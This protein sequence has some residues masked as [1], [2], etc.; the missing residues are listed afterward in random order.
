MAGHGNYPNI[1]G[2]AKHLSAFYP[3]V[4]ITFQLLVYKMNKF[5][6]FCL[7]FM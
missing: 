3:S 7:V 6:L 4:S 1:L 2:F 5:A